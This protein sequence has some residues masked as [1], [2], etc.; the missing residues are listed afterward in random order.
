MFAAVGNKVIAL[1]QQTIGAV[2][3]DVPEGQWRYL[4]AAEIGSFYPKNSEA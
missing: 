3:L 4:T 1:H 2:E